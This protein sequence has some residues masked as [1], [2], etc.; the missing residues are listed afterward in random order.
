M[1]EAGVRWLFLN[2]RIGGTGHAHCSTWPFYVTCKT[3]THHV[4]KETSRDLQP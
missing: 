2:P 3:M 1:Y 4:T